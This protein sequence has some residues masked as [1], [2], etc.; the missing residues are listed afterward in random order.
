M[1]SVTQ[2][3][4]YPASWATPEILEGADEITREA[5]VFA[6][7]MVVI[8]VCPRTSP[9]PVFE[10]GRWMVRLASESCLRFL[11]ESV[12]S[13]NSQLRQSFQRLWVAKAPL[14]RRRRKNEG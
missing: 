8:E 14:V 6:F 2:E 10:V 1:N 9:H 4:K 7:G 12:R 5:D 13:V 3:S 11:Q